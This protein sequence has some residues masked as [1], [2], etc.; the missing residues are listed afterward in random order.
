MDPL[1]SINTDTNGVTDTAGSA[2]DYL[3]DFRSGFISISD[4][5]SS[6]PA[7]PIMPFTLVC[8][9]VGFF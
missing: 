4:N 2:L 5:Q 7:H 9:L 8:C 3:E 6:Y 1:G